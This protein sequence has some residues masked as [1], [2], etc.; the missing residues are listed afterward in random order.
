[1]NKEARNTDLSGDHYKNL[2]LEIIIILKQYW[3]MINDKTP[4]FIP[5]NGSQ[6]C[7]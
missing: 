3:Y 2:D 7:I 6:D 5:P 4:I 1:M